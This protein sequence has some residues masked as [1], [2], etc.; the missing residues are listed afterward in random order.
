MSLG[1]DID[2]VKK[3]LSSDEKLLEQ[4]FHL[5]K[6]YKKN[7]KL[8]IATAILLMGAFIGY[9]V[10]NYLENKKLESANSALLTLTK[11]PTNKQA[12]AELKSNNPK[13]YNLYSYSA[14]LNGGNKEALA[15]IKSSDDFLQDVL[16]YHKGV[17]NKNPQDSEYYKDL[18][19]VEKAYK[20]IKEGKKQDAKNILITVPKTSAVAGVARLLEHYTIK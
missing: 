10:Y 19:L 17:L 3:E 6:F 14:A 13:L 12:L 7:K 5:E 16:G 1:D 2:A 4:A 9:K 18:V 8:I 15:A 20:L 11:D